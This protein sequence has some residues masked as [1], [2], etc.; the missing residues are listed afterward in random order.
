MDRNTGELTAAETEQLTRELT[1]IRP[2]GPYPGW[3]FDCAWT[4]PAMAPQLRRAIWT[5]HRDHAPETPLVLDWYDD[6]RVQTYWGSDESKQLYVGGCIEPNE[7]VFLADFLQPGMVFFDIGANNGLFTLFASRRVGHL[8]WVWAFEPSRREFARL[9]TNLCL[10]QLANVRA[11]SIAIANY[12]DTAEM[13]IAEGQHA[14]HNTLGC[15]GHPTDLLRMEVVH[16]RSLDRVV[17]DAG[18][19]RIDFIKIDAEGA[20]YAILDGARTVLRE[21]GPVLLLE[22]F[23][24]ALRHQ[25]SD[26]AAILAILREFDYLV[27]AF[28]PATG[29]PVLTTDDPW[30]GNII[31]APRGVPIMTPRGAA[32]HDGTNGS[33]AHAPLNQSCI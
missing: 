22:L 1:W 33:V 7:F 28:D 9:Q 29:G 30:E 6:L 32:A 12:N 24:A 31:A 2:F 4:N 17:A 16:V 8:G 11:E 15:F 23:P 3:R 19:H 20:E 10:N 18:L 26:P 14:G 25:G 21:I 27:Y 5:Y 13:K